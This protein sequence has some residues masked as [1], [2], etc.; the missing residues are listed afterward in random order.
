MS[1]VVVFC[2]SPVT[3]DVE[4]ILCTETINVSLDSLS[5]YYTEQ[6]RQR[7]WMLTSLLLYVKTDKQTNIHLYMGAVYC[8][9][10]PGLALTLLCSCRHRTYFAVFTR[11]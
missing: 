10:P 6:R 8:E 2:I 1:V 11:W 7:Y 4:C 9:T 3:I 5:T